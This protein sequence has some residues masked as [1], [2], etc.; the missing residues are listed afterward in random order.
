MRYWCIRSLLSSLKTAYV[1]M[2]PYDASVVREA[3]ATL[4]ECLG[5]LCVLILCSILFRA[6]LAILAASGI[7]RGNFEYRTM[8]GAL[9]VVRVSDNMDI[10]SL[11]DISPL[12]GR[13]LRPS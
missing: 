13:C 11:C 9:E 6:K 10:A 8:S 2:Q 12:V 4:V 7:D 3:L 5:N 1:A